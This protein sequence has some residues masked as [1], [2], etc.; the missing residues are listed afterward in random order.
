MRSSDIFK[1]Y[2]W[3]VKTIWQARRITLEELS[4]KWQACDLS[5][6]KPMS[7]STFNRHRKAV[8]DIFGILIECDRSAGNLYYITNTDDVEDNSVTSWLASTLA[9]D[10]IISEYRSVHNRILLEPVPYA[11]KTLQTIIEAIK[12]N[13]KVELIYQAYGKTAKQYLLAPYC[14]RLFKQRWY[15]L[16]YFT[17]KNGKAKYR[18]FSFDRMVKAELSEQSFRMDKNFDCKAFFSEYYGIMT[19]DSVKCQRIVIRAHGAEAYYLHDLPLHHSQREI[20]STDSATDFELYLRPTPDFLAAVFS[21][22]GRVEI[23]SPKELKDE[24]AEWSKNMLE[25]INSN[26][27]SQS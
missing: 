11:G 17:D 24:Q 12:Y 9:T 25:R 5:Y 16:G 15:M 3:L 10:C 7:R 8:E 22:A 18:L 21:R 19:D 26:M 13:R 4:R 2:V 14:I 27:A 23:L 20:K 1:E 6:G